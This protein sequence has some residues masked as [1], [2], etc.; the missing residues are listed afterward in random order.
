LR[1]VAAC[2]LVAAV[3]AAAAGAA[4]NPEQLRLEKTLRA[5]MVKT[6]KKR[7]PSLRITAVTCK[8]P[9]NGTVARCTARFTTGSVDGWYPV[10]AVLHDS[11]LLTWTATSPKCFDAKTKKRLPC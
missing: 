7:A 2:L 6:F 5:N 10:K 1:V 8:L 3:L 9:R 11:G 4:T